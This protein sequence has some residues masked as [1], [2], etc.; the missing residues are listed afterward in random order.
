MRKIDFLHKKTFALLFILFFF[1]SIS[2]PLSAQT[3]LV[4]CGSSDND[5][6]QLLQKEG[7]ATQRYD[8]LEQA[9][10]QVQKGMG[11]MVI[12]DGYP[13]KRVEISASQYDVIKRKEIRLYVEYPEF[14]PGHILSKESYVGKLERGVI[15]SDFFGNDL[16]E[17]SILGIN[18]CHIIPVKV[19]KSIIS[20][21]KV[22]GFDKAQYGLTD[23]GVYPLLF[24]EDNL[25]IATTGLSNFKRARFGPS[26]S[27]KTVWESLLSWV[28]GKEKLTFKE[29]QFD[30]YP[31]YSATAELPANARKKAIGNGA[32]WL[33][34][35]RLFIHPSWE[36][37]MLSKYQPK[38]GD[39]NLFFGPPIG[40]DLLVGDGSRGIMEGHASAINYDGTQQYRYFVRADI[41]GESAFLLA[42]SGSLLDN[43]EYKK[44]SE[45]LLDYLFYTS[46]FRGGDKNNKDTDVYGLLGWANT[47]LGVF[48][49]DDNA[50]C[51]LGVIGTSAF[52]K[53]ERWNKFIVENILANLRTC[54][55]QGFQGNAL[56]Q[57]QIQEKGWRYYNERDYTNPNPHFESW[58][59]A[60][61]LWLYDKTHYKPLL[62]KAKAG[63]KITMDAYPDKWI[64]TNGIQ[65]ERA[66]MILPL[67][68]L[69][70]VE[71]TQE[72]RN[73][74]DMVVT[75]LLESQVS[76]GAIREE[77]G[78]SSS[79]KNKYNQYFV[80][81]N[82]AY[83][84]SE[85]SLIAENGDPVSDMLYTCNFGF[86]ALN[87]AAQATG[88]PKYKEAV[89]KLSD[90]LV[91]I[92]VKSKN[93]IDTDGAWFRAFDYN[94]WDY[95]A[96]NA[97]N[98]WGA[99][100]T[101]TGWIQS[102]IVVTQV[103]VEKNQ[104][105]WVAT[106]NINIK[107]ELDESLWMLK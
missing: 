80:S 36:K 23:T 26:N 52:L 88:N 79:D 30:P 105:Y 16:P 2:T 11:V 28:S 53:N 100:S 45:K 95:W 27:W 44:T 20:F 85:A 73:W 47:H 32:E 40:K 69:V 55:K 39:P 75:K 83:G 43:N 4:F 107:R 33:S 34:N 92:Q 101:L 68:W 94:R 96:S 21:A 81:S 98:G 38:N 37:E 84:T 89:K 18:G 64:S 14:I 104:S 78:S 90:F 15:S 99:W 12:A 7:I 59:W 70:R 29:W 93:H 50:R 42:A 35:A 74:L 56:N 66:R 13:A 62:D 6:Y 46:D 3:P 103:L 19:K 10:P 41:Q 61:Y 17:M 51:L 24:K 72:H 60:C 25:L 22:A 1:G 9:L 77:L 8:N 76:C 63:I 54:S 82:K 91:R 67:A 86:F 97:D 5:L 49:N 58:M 65:Q 102:W 31:A 48:Y 71:D 87:E 57:Q 106:K